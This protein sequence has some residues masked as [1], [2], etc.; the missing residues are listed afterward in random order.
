MAW[1]SLGP[2]SRLRAGGVSLGQE[3]FTPLGG[4]SWQ[5]SPK[6]GQVGRMVAL[7]PQEGLESWW[8]ENE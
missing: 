7:S 2:G 4:R 1:S 6:D 5:A 3:H 8:K